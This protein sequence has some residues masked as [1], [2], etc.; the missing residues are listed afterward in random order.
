NPRIWAV[1]DS[2]TAGSG[3][4]TGWAWRQHVGKM[5][6]DAG[7]AF[8]SVG[9]VSSAA[10]NWPNHW[11]RSGESAANVEAD[12]IA[13]GTIFTT[14][15]PDIICLTPIGQNDINLGGS[16]NDARD[17]V[18]SLLTYIRGLTN[19]RG[20][21]PRVVTAKVIGHRISDATMTAFAG[22]M[23]A[24]YA[25]QTSAGLDLYVVEFR[26]GMRCPLTALLAD[27]QHPTD[28]GYRRIAD[29]IFPALMNAIGLDAEW[30]R[31]A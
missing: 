13:D 10:T 18:D 7:V 31:A 14:A 17:A 5:L 6:T 21:T 19:G 16:A 28:D 27:E 3:G 22:L 23:D 4:T 8:T 25:A 11:G 1:G 2:L 26:T 12:M 15:D 29:A 20:Q 24:V 9:S 30:G